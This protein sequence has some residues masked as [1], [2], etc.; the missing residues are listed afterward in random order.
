[1]AKAQWALDGRLQKLGFELS[2]T[3]H[4]RGLKILKVELKI[5]IQVYSM[6]TTHVSGLS[7]DGAPE[8]GMVSTPCAL[9]ITSITSQALYP[10]EPVQFGHSP[11]TRDTGFLFEWEMV[12]SYL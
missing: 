4:K 10:E 6:S 8:S 5:E 1:M 7:S 9:G 11:Y 2:S 12:F 3:A